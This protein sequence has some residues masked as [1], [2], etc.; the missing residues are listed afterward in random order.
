MRTAIL[1]V[2]LTASLFGKACIK[3]PKYPEQKCS[4][5]SNIDAPEPASFLLMGA[6]LVGCGVILRRK[7]KSAN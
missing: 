6:G 5:P 7:K 2:T 4:D 3:D 1:A